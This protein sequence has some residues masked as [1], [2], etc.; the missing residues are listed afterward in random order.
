MTLPTP[1]QL[2]E[3]KALMEKANERPYVLGTGREFGR[4]LA[5]NAPA[6]IEAAERCAELEAERDRLRAALLDLDSLIFH[7]QQ[8]IERAGIF[9]EH[10]RA[11]LLDPSQTKETGND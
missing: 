2:A 11:A 6:L 7:D 8:V 4:A 3:L 10:I 9:R 5:R 1:E